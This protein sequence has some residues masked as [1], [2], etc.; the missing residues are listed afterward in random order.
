MLPN[1]LAG[2]V[3]ACENYDFQSAEAQEQFE[4]LM[5]RLREQLMQRY[6]DQMSG[7]MGACRPRTCSG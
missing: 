7:A 6:V 2:Q 3:R 1:D 4:E 5:E